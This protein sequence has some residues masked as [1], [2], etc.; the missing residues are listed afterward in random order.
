MVRRFGGRQSDQYG[1]HVLEN[2]TILGRDDGAPVDESRRQDRLR[3]LVLR[4]L[5]RRR[6]NG[7]P[8]AADRPAEFRL[9]VFGVTDYVGK[10]TTLHYGAVTARQRATGRPRGVP[11]AGQTL[12]E[13]VAVY[14]GGRPDQHPLVKPDVRLPPG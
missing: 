2:E 1:R 13:W 8:V 6:R 12:A 3:I 4:W 14:A 9:L 11:Q 10:L 5:G 7:L